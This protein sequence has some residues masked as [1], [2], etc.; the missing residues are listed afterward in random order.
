M[1][2]GRKKN[3]ENGRI[4][5]VIAVGVVGTNQNLVAFGNF[6]IFRF[7]GYL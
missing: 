7:V 5:G 4:R 6:G 3:K 2:F 1:Y